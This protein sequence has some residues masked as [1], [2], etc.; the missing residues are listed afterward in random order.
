[1]IRADNMPLVTIVN[2]HGVRQHG[3]LGSVLTM[4]A[5]VVLP[6]WS[7]MFLLLAAD[8]MST[9]WP[10]LAV[11]S[12]GSPANTVGSQRLPRAPRLVTEQNQQQSMATIQGEHLEL[13]D[14]C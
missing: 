10:S 14:G 7:L 8:V 6:V 11:Q 5:L 13:S 3:Y 9:A 1:M 12:A 4:T 2:R